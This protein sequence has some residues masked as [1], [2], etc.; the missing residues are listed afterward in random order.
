MSEY[1]V[2]K[3]ENSYPL[4]PLDLKTTKPCEYELGLIIAYTSELERGFK[5]GN[6]YKSDEDGT[7]IDFVPFEN[8]E[9]IESY[10]KLIL[11]MAKD[12]EQKYE[13]WEILSLLKK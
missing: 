10:E 8:Q 11:K 5:V 7:K 2:K 12:F 9:D 3:I 4:L 6:Q 13:G 1:S